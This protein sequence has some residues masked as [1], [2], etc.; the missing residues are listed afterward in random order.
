MR[1]L[2]EE[3]ENLRASL[4]RARDSLER[5]KR[6]NASIKHKKVLVELNC[7]AKISKQKIRKASNAKTNELL[8]K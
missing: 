8:K 4:F 1:R 3:V 6:L 5:E 7:V 2:T